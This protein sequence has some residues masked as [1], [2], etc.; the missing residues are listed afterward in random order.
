MI[1]IT[2]SQKHIDDVF[3][4][5]ETK[6]YLHFMRKG[7]VNTKYRPESSQGVFLIKLNC[8]HYILGEYRKLSNKNFTVICGKCGAYHTITRAFKSRVAM[9]TYHSDTPYEDLES[10]YKNL[11]IKKVPSGYVEPYS[12]RYHTADC[13][14]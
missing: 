4:E 6:F 2:E 14:L 9:Y 7:M 1:C 10:F 11:E 13:L 8:G 12:T 5:V 3:G